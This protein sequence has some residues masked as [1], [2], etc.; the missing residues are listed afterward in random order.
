MRL[1][2][3]SSR[4]RKSHSRQN[5]FGPRDSEYDSDN[6]VP[7]VCVENP[8]DPRPIHGIQRGRQERGLFVKAMTYGLEIEGM[9]INPID[10]GSLRCEHWKRSECPQ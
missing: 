2:I 6:A 1:K 9:A 10:R 4:L 3:N 8:A 5:F 7:S